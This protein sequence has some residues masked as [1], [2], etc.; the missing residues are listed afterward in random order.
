MLLENK[1]VHYICGYFY[2]RKYKEKS[3]RIEN[4]ED[5]PPY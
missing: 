1:K 3:K 4:P 5:L 2:Y